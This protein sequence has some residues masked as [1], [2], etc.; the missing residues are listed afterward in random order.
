MNRISALRDRF[1]QDELSEA[2]FTASIADIVAATPER[3]G[4]SD[5]LMISQQIR[6]LEKDWRRSCHRLPK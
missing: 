4:P 2:E 3:I 6:K 1:G 5:S